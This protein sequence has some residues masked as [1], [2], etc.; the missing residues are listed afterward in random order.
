MPAI[1]HWESLTRVD[2]G[3]YIQQYVSLQHCCGWY[4]DLYSPAIMVKRTQTDITSRIM[5]VF[6][7]I[8]SSAGVA[9]PAWEHHFDEV[10]K[11]AVATPNVFVVC[12]SAVIPRTISSEGGV[13][14]LEASGLPPEDNPAGFSS[15]L[16]SP[17]TIFN[18]RKDED[19]LKCSVETDATTVLNKVE[20]YGWF[21]YQ[22]RLA[23]APANWFRTRRY[24]F[25]I[26]QLPRQGVG[27]FDFYV[28]NP[29]SIT[30]TFRMDDVGFAKLGANPKVLS[31]RV[32]E[33]TASDDEILSPAPVEYARQYHFSSHGSLKSS[34]R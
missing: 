13:H 4:A 5:A 15:V 26:S 23:G 9:I 2:S 24:P 34:E 16:G 31:I 19:G 14:W 10:E 21:S 27:S 11:R 33:P 3:H 20:L 1:G 30:A 32:V 12:H 22:D 8:I 7:L 25:T 28:R 17:G 6:A 29:T 18:M